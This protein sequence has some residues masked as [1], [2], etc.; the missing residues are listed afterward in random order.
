MKE[1]SYLITLDIYD[2]NTDINI[3][4]VERRDL[5]KF[6]NNFD[7][8]AS[9]GNTFIKH[10]SAPVSIDLSHIFEG[11]AEFVFDTDFAPGIKFSIDLNLQGSFIKISG[12]VIYKVKV[13]E[14]FC[15]RVKVDEIPE[16]FIKEMEIII[17]SRSRLIN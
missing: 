2:H 1:G 9:D 16:A 3:I 14:N 7:H 15:I 5:M 17:S 6:N 13:G 8:P 12:D 10:V 4:V 11:Y